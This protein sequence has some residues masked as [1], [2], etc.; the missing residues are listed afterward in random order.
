MK[1]QSSRWICGV[2]AGVILSTGLT[3]CVPLV[4]GGG[5]AVGAMVA[6]DRRTSGTQL[7]DETIELRTANRIRD[8]LGDRGHVNVTSWNRQVLL[9]GEVPAPEDRQKIEQ[10]ALSGENVRSVVNELVAAPNASLS[11]RS[12]DTLITGKVKASFVDAKDIMSSAF[13]VV[14]ER[15]IVYLMG[16]VTQREATR[17][18]EITRG[19]GGVVKVV[20]VFEIISEDEL[21]NATAARQPAPV[22]SDLDHPAQ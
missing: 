16:R 8:L 13:K 17:A 10:I 5:A 12:N 21:R 14:T 18:T 4:M 11:Q 2:W 19:V 3:A 20:R 22:T 7:E 1:L 9:T 15:G 6:V